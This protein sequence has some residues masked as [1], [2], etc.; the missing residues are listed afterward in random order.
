MALGLRW[1]PRA[2]KGQ[3]GWLAKTDPTAL[4]V[5]FTRVVKGRKPLYSFTICKNAVHVTFCIAQR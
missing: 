3:W 1:I 2:A 4:A 5:R